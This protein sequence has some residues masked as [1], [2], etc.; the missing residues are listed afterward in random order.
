MTTVIEAARPEWTAFA[1][2]PARVRFAG[3]RQIAVTLARVM[4]EAPEPLAEAARL[5]RD[6]PGQHSSIIETPTSILAC[7]DHCRSFPVFHTV[8]QRVLIGNDAAAVR[9]ESGIA[10]VDSASVI[11]CALAG[12]S[13]GPHTLYAGLQQLEP[14]QAM[15]WDRASG[16]CSSIRYFRYLPDAYSA[17]SDDELSEALI[18]SVDKAIDRTIEAAGDRPIAVPLSGGLDSRLIVAK[19]HARG[20]RNLL[21][22]SYGQAGNPDAM[23]AREIAAALNL[24]WQFVDTLAAANRAFFA[25]SDRKRYWQYAD[26]LSTVPNNQDILPLLR[27]RERGQL[28]E[29]SV[30]V[31]GQTGDFISGGHIPDALFEQDLTVGSLVDRIAARHYSLWHPIETPDNHVIVT[32]RIRALLDL[33]ETEDT[34]IDRPRAIALWELFEYETRQAR[35]IVNGQRVYDHLN[36]A[37]HLPLW[38]GDFVRFWRDAPQA[39]KRGQ[40]LYRATWMKW[41]YRKLFSRHTRKVSAWSRPVSM[42]IVPLSIATRLLVGRRRRDKLIAYARYFDRFGNHYQSFGWSAFSRNARHIRNP[43]ALYV[44]TWLEERGLA[45]NL[46]NGAPLL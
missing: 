14:G 19:L 8:G 5:L 26:H 43:V 22:F 3:D 42:A 27:L 45:G 41:D 25:G 13:S 40:S 31:N 23:I 12:F 24:P 16:H 33:R 2:G 10:K 7:V 44:R 35:Y 34:R 20:C 1:V 11:E 39:S 28:P 15:L 9:T 32:D 17:A 4:A 37:W 36:L 30:M 18:A 46:W 6:H 38:D 21:T 29:N